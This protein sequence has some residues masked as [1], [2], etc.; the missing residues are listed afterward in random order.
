ME[1]NGQSEVKAVSLQK[2]E[3]NR[4]N[5]LKSTGPKTDQGKRAVRFNAVKD[6]FFAKQ[7]LL[8]N[9]KDDPEE[10]EALLKQLR[11]DLQPVGQLE[12]LLVE[13]IA[14]CFWKSRRAL[15]CEVAEAKQNASEAVEEMKKK[16][17]DPSTAEKA[18]DSLKQAREKAEKELTGEEK[19]ARLRDIDE[20]IRD[21]EDSQQKLRDPLE[22]RANSLT[23]PPEKDLDRILRY[24]KLM[25]VHDR[26]ASPSGAY[27]SAFRI[28]RHASTDHSAAVGLR[29]D[30]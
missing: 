10:F 4:R 15:R 6:G 22:V 29:L 26:N 12:G 8:S 20:R 13:R 27:R 2:V 28:E 17:K 24:D 5:V 23:L 25:I 14:V 11:E 7:I 9:L 1:D 21:F 3:A 19:E 18:I 16:G 30:R